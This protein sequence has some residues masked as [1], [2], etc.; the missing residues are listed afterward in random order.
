MAWIDAAG[1]VCASSSPSQP[2][3]TR[4][5]ASR[6]A[7]EAHNGQELLVQSPAGP[8][9]ERV[10]P[11]VELRLSPWYTCTA[12]LSDGPVN[13]ASSMP[14]FRRKQPMSSRPPAS[15]AICGRLPSLRLLG[16]RAVAAG[17]AVLWQD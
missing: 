1:L 11:G 5:Y 6:L 17:S 8:P 16:R 2:R 3:S 13:S 4:S 7:F 9:D 12:P 10:G 15:R 14:T